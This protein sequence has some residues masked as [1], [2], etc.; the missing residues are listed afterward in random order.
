[1]S[2]HPQLTAYLLGELSSVESA[3]LEAQL[4]ASP[5]LQQEL[6]ALRQTVNA[7][8]SAFAQRVDVQ[9]AVPP[10]DREKLHSLIRSAVV[11][12]PVGQAFL[13][14][15]GAGKA[16]RNVCS[17]VSAPA[18]LASTPSRSSN[19][20]SWLVAGAALVVGGLIGL[21]Q[22]E[23]G[24]REQS[25]ARVQS[26]P[27]DRE[28]L[29][30][31][32][33]TIANG[34]GGEPLSQVELQVEQKLSE[35][36]ASI[37]AAS[38]TQLRA[39]LVPIDS[40][41]PFDALSEGEPIVSA[42]GASERVL[43]FSAEDPNS[44]ATR[45][46]D[47]KTDGL[48]AEASVRNFSTFLGRVPRYQVPSDPS[49]P[50]PNNYSYYTHKGPSA[51]FRGRGVAPQEVAGQSGWGA[52]QP[53]AGRLY[54]YAPIDNDALVANGERRSYFLMP[55]DAGIDAFGRTA[56]TSHPL[57]TSPDDV[58]FYKLD[59]LPLAESL[60]DN[61][62]ILDLYAIDGRTP[63]SLDVIDGEQKLMMMVRP[64]IIVQRRGYQSGT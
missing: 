11:T 46:G 16:D 43:S 44:A 26:S 15:A 34:R 21:S 30:L 41:A 17:T 45:F 3:A 32:S 61:N 28:L 29:E 51:Y 19:S 35:S 47:S 62:G 38:R 31:R 33:S 37:G 14:A 56:P 48:S 58:D 42:T 52:S 20:R 18:L 36:V 25:L 6:D 50:G 27:R 49:Q 39:G 4:A 9:L 10:I 2:D 8:Q 24:P 1:M 12:S 54:D 63:E 22:W 57:T 53:S 40:S 7:L 59:R 23:V 64:R 13:P 5:E 55:A 60:T